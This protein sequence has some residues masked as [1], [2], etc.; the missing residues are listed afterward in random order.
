MNTALYRG[1]ILALLLAACTSSNAGSTGSP[2]AGAT[3]DAASDGGTTVSD[4]GADPD[5]TAQ[6][7]LVVSAATSA[8]LNGSYALF[9]DRIVD[10]AGVAYNGSLP[11][12]PDPA[13]T[14]PRIEVEVVT[15]GATGK[16]KR[17]HFWN[18]DAA[19]STPEKFFGCDG[20]TALPCAGIAVD[21]ASKKVTFSAVVWKEV[22]ADLTGAAPDVVVAGGGSVTLNGI[23][24]VR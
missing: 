24:K 5:A 21:D 4:A 16:V 11:E 20:T 17:A 1:T 9:V 3:A 2:D 10:G 13:A 6:G 23:V 15:D 8:K 19:G 18:Y 12:L 22:T 7:G 14:K